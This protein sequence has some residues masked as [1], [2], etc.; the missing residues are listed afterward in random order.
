TPAALD[1]MAA[2]IDAVPEAVVGAGTVLSPGQFHEVAQRGARFVVTPGTTERL[3]DAAVKHNIPLL[4]GCATASEVVRL[5]ERGIHYMKFFPA[6]PAG[7]IP[8]LKALSSPLPEAKFCPTGGV[9]MANARDYLALP[10]V[11]CVG[12]SWLVPQNAVGEGNWDR[13]T[14]LAL[15]ASALK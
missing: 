14:E 8:Y 3:I 13:L 5:L 11:V 1:A 12:G 9:S 10:N 15:E 2:I 6:G 7:G 4:P